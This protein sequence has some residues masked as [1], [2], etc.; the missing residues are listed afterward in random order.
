MSASN[1]LVLEKTYCLNIGR[2][3]WYFFFLFLQS[4]FCSVFHLIQALSVA[5]N[6]SQGT[7]ICGLTACWTVHNTYLIL[8]LLFV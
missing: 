6:N 4:P 8:L 3:R 1:T 5:F 2:K 7:G